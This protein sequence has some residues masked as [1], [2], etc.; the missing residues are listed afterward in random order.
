MVGINVYYD[1]SIENYLEG[2]LVHYSFSVTNIHLSIRLLV[3]LINNTNMYGLGVN[4]Q[5]ALI[6]N[7]NISRINDG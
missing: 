3:L 1:F 5:N 4:G 6:I 2:T 7:D